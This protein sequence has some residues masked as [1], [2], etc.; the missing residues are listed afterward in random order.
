VLEARAQYDG[1]RHIV[2]VRVGGDDDAIYLDLANDDWE[3]VQITTEGWQVMADA[4]VRF[5][6]PRGMLPLPTPVPGG[7][8]DGL[9][10]FVNVGGDED[11]QTLVQAFAVQALRPRGPYA[12][13]EF[14]G[15]QGLRNPRQP[16]S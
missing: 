9:L 14:N 11:R 16:R 4:P 3:S 15:E 5:R 12:P 10:E 8:L 1:D 2:N 6:R 13:L 7:S